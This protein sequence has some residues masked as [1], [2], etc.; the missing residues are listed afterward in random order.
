MV[1]GVTEEV[2]E[3]MA[4]GSFLLAGGQLVAQV[5][6]FAFSVVIARLLGPGAY[7][8]A[9]VAMVY[10]FLL[11]SL[12]SLGLEV[13]VARCIASP[14][15]TRGVYAWTGLLTRL[16]AASVAGLIT[17]FYSG[18][19][20]SLLSR[21]EVEPLIRVLSLY[22]VFSSLMGLVNAAL[23][24]LG[25][26]KAS[27]SMN[28]LYNVVRGPLA[29]VLVLA[30][31]GAYG[32]VLSH[33]V[34]SVV[35]FLLYLVPYYSFFKKPVFSQVA[36]RELLA[37][38]LPLYAAGLVSTFTGPVVNT[39]LSN[40]VTSNELGNY[41]VASNAQLPLGAL[42]GAISTAVLTTFPLLLENRGAFR[43]RVSET[44][45]YASTVSAA[46][47]FCY[48]SIIMPLV[49]L[50]YGR[51]YAT[52]HVYALVL[53]LSYILPALLASTVT[54]NVFIALEDTR[55]N[56]ALNA[57]SVTSTITLAYTLVPRLGVLGACV[58]Y[59]VGNTVS[60]ALG[61]LVLSRVFSVGVNLGKTLK[62][63]T[64]AIVAFLASTTV[65]YIL[66][67][68]VT[69]QWFTVLHLYVAGI[70]SSILVGLLVYAFSYLALLPRFLDEHSIRVIVD[71]AGKLEY[72]GRV[73]KPLG[74]LYLKML[75]A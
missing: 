70:V 63:S 26:Y 50:A 42:L 57:V 43:R 33:T 54:G 5:V 8:L 45:F 41:G 74:E 1:C 66:M 11:A 32:A 60:S 44:A 62:A 13:A 51:A 20:A 73:I 72:V 18:L 36:L 61:L 64:P 7:G 59:V 6:A 53:A 65:S 71:L 27:A 2:S 16:V 3:R 55:W 46:L 23:S 29:V 40:T 48:A 12:S 31:L 25:E 21:P 68:L 30:G 4:R 24:G 28:I 34:A 58:A 56:I 14:S 38:A 9:T 10:P 69:R 37:L 35:V 22:V 47:G 19:F 67:E 39:I 17:Y 75:S 52:A 49:R 15:T